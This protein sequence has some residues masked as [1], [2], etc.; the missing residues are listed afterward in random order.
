MAADCGAGETV[1]V[2]G[3]A[4]SFRGDLLR[5]LRALL[6]DGAAGLKG[7]QSQG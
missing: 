3:P 4:A 7:G 1:D 5:K 6:R 2:K